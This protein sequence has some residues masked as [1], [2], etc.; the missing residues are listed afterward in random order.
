MKI[1]MRVGSLASL[2]KAALPC[3]AAV[4]GMV[5]PMAVYLLVQRLCGGGSLSALTVPMATDIAFAM[6]VFGLFRKRMPPAASAF[7]LT[8]A[9]V[10]DLGAILVLATCFA[11]HVSLPFLGGAAAIT[12]ALAVYGRTLA[13]DLR[14]FAA[15]GAALWY[16]LLRSGINADI[17]GV[18]AAFCISTRAQYVNRDGRREDVTHRAVLRLSPL[19]TFFIM[20]LFA[21]ANTAIPLGAIPA[22]GASAAAAAK[23][24]AAASVAPALGI[25]AGLLLGKPLG[26]FTF[27]LLAA[28]LNLASL[29]AGMSKLH[30]AIVGVL[31]GIGFTMCLLLTEVAMP[32]AQR[33]L[34]KMVILLSSLL[35]SLVAAAAMRALPLLSETK[36]AD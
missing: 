34:P 22:A 31:G 24:A 17:A 19:S 16:C 33:T 4:G 18:L 7:L 35:A 10:D 2:R 30:L 23:A 14:A 3:I 11:S 27:S 6:A 26:I 25:G 15:G 36:K 29:P 13:S 32:A 8:L 9:T 20:P 1:E 5:T 28:K 21:L 12:A